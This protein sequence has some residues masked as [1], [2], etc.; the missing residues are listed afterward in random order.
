IRFCE[1]FSL[2]EGTSGRLRLKYSHAGGDYLP[3]W[4]PRHTAREALGKRGGY[5]GSPRPGS[6]HGQGPRGPGG[7]GAGAATL[8][9]FLTTLVNPAAA[10]GDEALRQTRR[11]M[12]GF[13]AAETRPYCADPSQGL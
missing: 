7:T 5:P 4:L 10:L 3:G 6:A 13:T 2:R 11:R 1:R 8:L 9:L 12:S